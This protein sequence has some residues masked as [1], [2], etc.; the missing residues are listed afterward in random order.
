MSH[1]EKLL[2]KA[3][4]KCERP[5]Y[6]AL[7]ERM[8]VTSAS[9]SQFKLG[10]VPMPDERIVQAA[11]IAG[12][13]PDLWLLIVKAEQ[14]QGEAGKVWA[15]LARKFGAA[16]AIFLCVVSMPTPASTF[17]QLGGH[18]GSEIP[19]NAYYVQT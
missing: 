1:V 5:S 2:D 10:Q 4:H 6:R 17:K 11:K 18:L 12:E 16:A 15:R 19:T 3:A 8:G 14:T 13:D 7:A 9:L